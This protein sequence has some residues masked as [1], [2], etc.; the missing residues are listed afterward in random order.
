MALVEK[1]RLYRNLRDRLVRSR[2]A[3]AGGVRPNSAYIVP[4]CATVL[5]TELARQV[6]RMNSSAIR[7]ESQIQF[8]VEFVIQDFQHNFHP[9]CGSRATRHSRVAAELSQKLQH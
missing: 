5:L 2:E 3:L 7:N 4:N 1:A 8:L 9:S 6:H